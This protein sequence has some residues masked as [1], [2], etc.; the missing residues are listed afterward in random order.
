MC[1]VKWDA[2][3]RSP[4]FLAASRAKEERFF[5][6]VLLEWSLREARAK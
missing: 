2:G 6:S 4:F 5:F 3:I 1:T